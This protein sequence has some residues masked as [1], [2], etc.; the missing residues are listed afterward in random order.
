MI[1]NVEIK[2]LLLPE[3]LN[4]TTPR[5]AKVYIFSHFFF[6]RYRQSFIVT[7]CIQKGTV[8]FNVIPLCL[9][10]IALSHWAK[11]MI[12]LHKQILSRKDSA[13]ARSVN[14]F[15]CTYNHVI[16][17]ASFIRTRDPADLN[18]LTNSSAARIVGNQ[19]LI[20]LSIQ[21]M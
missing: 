21:G 19:G 12:T 17:S 1:K 3:W 18:P 4:V 5:S 11:L 6:F 2:T 9:H 15:N 16:L 8:S 10:H 20:L 13:E 7:T 14:R